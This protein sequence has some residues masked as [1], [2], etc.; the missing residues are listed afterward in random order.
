MVY[1]TIVVVYNIKRKPGIKMNKKERIIEYLK[2]KE[3]GIV[4]DIIISSD[5]V[6]QYFCGGIDP[7]DEI[8]ENVDYDEIADYIIAAN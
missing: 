1:T 8:P 2:H 4:E 6:Y 3:A 7:V 5:E